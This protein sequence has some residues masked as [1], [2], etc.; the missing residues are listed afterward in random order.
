M[1]YI[2]PADRIQF[3]PK[4]KE[5]ISVITN[6]G[7]SKAKVGDINYVFSKIIWELF[8]KNPSYTLGNDL[9]GVLEGVR[10]EFYRRKLGPYEDQKMK[11]NGDIQ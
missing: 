1:P 4:I 8:D 9:M 6:N 3:D 5:V 2:I 11:E 10:S 7:S